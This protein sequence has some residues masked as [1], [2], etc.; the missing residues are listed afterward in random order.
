MGSVAGNVREDEQTPLAPPDAAP[1][2]DAPSVLRLDGASGFDD[3]ALE[4]PSPTIDIARA[5]AIKGWMSPTELR[6]LA[7]RAAESAMVLEIGCALGRATRALG[8]H[9]RG[10]VW[11]VDPWSGDYTNNNGTDARWFRKLAPSGDAMFA[12][13]QEHV[14]DLIAMG[15]VLPVRATA[16]DA[17]QQLAAAGQFDLVFLDGDHR[18]REVVSDIDRFTP[19]VRSGGILAGHDYG[20]AD[21]PGV[22]QAVDERFLAA[23]IVDTI[24]WVRL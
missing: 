22:K 21:W 4:R 10:A 1:V 17:V 13:F 12:R 15:R 19:L 7:E 6:W 16:R 14:A 11:S 23:Q 18:Y 24:W 8:D 5:Q 2:I 9:V 20:R 3:A